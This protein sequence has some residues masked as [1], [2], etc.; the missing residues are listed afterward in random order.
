MCVFASPRRKEGDLS[1]F[2]KSRLILVDDPCEDEDVA[3]RC[4]RQ[5]GRLKKKETCS[6]AINLSP[7]LR[8]ITS[9]LRVYIP[10]KVRKKRNFVV[11]FIKLSIEISFFEKNYYYYN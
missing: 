3:R 7:S 9:L 10:P 5:F 4:V 8:K 2:L 1:L 6:N 11:F